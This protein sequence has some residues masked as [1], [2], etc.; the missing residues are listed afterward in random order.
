VDDNLPEHLSQIPSQWSLILRAGDPDAEPKGEARRELLLRYHEAVYHYFRRRVRDEHDAD[1]LYSNFALRL[2]E[3]NR[4]VRGADPERGRFR[5]YL[6]T[7]LRRMADD[8]FREKARK[9]PDPLPADRPDPRGDDP[10]ADVWPQELLNQAWKALEAH[11]RGTGQPFYT[12]LRLVSD[13]AQASAGRLQAQDL[14]AELA[15]RLGRPFTAAN[16]RKVLE[17]ARR[18]F[19]ELLLE[20]VERGLGDPTPEALEDELCEIGLFRFCEATLKGR[21]T[22]AGTP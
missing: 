5:A 7:I 15:A 11:E 18:R 3:D 16:A 6:G 4:L 20:E 2:S 9:S 8:H 14:A 13:H 1:E 21:Q 10:F 12:A 19:G 22:P 17:R